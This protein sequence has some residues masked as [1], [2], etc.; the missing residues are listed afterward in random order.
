MAAYCVFDVL[1]ITDGPKMDEYRRGVRA[2][3]ERHG[4]RYLVIGGRTEVVEGD[5]RPTLPVIIEFPTFEAARGWYDSEEYR[6]LKAMRL[7]ATRGHMC[8]IDGLAG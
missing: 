8:I 1:E 4:G 2:T 7:A 3:V 6:E 5:W